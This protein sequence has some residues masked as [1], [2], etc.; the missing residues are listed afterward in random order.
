M[1]QGGAA[2]AAKADYDRVEHMR[3]AIPI[4]APSLEHAPIEKNRQQ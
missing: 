1:K 3:L 2:N 4:C